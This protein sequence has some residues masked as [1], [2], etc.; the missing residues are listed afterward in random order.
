MCPAPASS[1]EGIVE[2]RKLGII[3]GGFMGRSIAEKIASQG[4]DVIVVEASEERARRSL[5]ELAAGLD[6]ELAKWGITPSEK[7]AILGRVR[8]TADL[9]E[10]HVAD[11]VIETV[12][13]DLE[14]KKN[15]MRGLDVVC[16][17]DRMLITN[18]STLSIT[19][20]AA[21]SGR[22]D[23]VVG[24]HFMHPVT[25]SPVVEV[26]RGSET[27]QETFATALE[28]ARLL[29]KTPIEVFEYPGYVV[30]RAIIPF[31]NEAMHITM[32]GVAS[33]DHVD[34]A[35]KL[36]YE[37]KLGPL[38]YADR[39]GLDVV[40]G[41]MEHLFQEL[42]DVKYRPCP[43]LRKLVR[44]GRLGRKTGQ[45]FFTYRGYERVPEARETAPP[46]P[47]PQPEGAR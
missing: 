27:S 24:M 9:G 19:E 39:V 2:F 35:I 10:V 14:T 38:E 26:V 12:T 20:I 3:G 34:Q 1:R 13:E 18:T 4:I 6:Q 25:L 5:E 37:F 45:G 17:P 32:E 7:K 42:G 16:P 43:L 29:D 22:P 36:S 28:L 8:F 15:V 23:R 46:A 40:L 41:W 11:L 21:A 33:A 44:A 30:T 47:E 31:L